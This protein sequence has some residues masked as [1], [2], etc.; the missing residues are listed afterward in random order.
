[1]V[2]HI[3]SMWHKRD[4]NLTTEAQHSSGIQQKR[5][6]QRCHVEIL[7]HL[8]VHEKLNQNNVFEQQFWEHHT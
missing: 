7:Y 3:S 2:L 1:M 5:G 6:E 8:N 4:G